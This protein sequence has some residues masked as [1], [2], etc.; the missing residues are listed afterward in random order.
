MEARGMEFVDDKAGIHACS[1]GPSA[2]KKSKPGD[3]KK[4]F[5]YEWLRNKA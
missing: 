1:F 3:F 4:L 2:V 5:N